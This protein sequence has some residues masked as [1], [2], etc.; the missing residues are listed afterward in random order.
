M[1]RDGTGQGRGKNQDGTSG[2]YGAREHGREGRTRE[3]DLSG[4][5]S[6]WGQG[7]G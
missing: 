3:R 6:E 1:F 4:E 5:G 2:I 7:E